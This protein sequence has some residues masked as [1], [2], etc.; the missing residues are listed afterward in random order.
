M[1]TKNRKISIKKAGGNAGLKSIAYNLGLP[2]LWVKKLGVTP[3]DRDITITYD[4]KNDTII[5][6]KK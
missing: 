1:E 6:K 5:I 2:T 4:E 3:E